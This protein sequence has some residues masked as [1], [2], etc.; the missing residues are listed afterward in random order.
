MAGVKVDGL[1]AIRR[2]E[3]DGLGQRVSARV[4]RTDSSSVWEGLLV[5]GDEP[6]GGKA[7]F[8]DVFAA[9]AAAY[10]ELMVVDGAEEAEGF[11]DLP[12]MRLRAT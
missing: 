1:F 7:R 5:D 4:G 10:G 12:T 9:V 6:L 2:L 8:D 11:Q 3:L